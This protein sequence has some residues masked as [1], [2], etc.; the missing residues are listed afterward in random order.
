MALELTF[1]QDKHMAGDGS[2]LSKICLKEIIVSIKD[3]RKQIHI[4]HW[5]VLLALVMTH[6]GAYPWGGICSS[7]ALVKDV[8]VQMLVHVEFCVLQSL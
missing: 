8:H 5:M 6:R 3:V 1:Y 2:K 4:P 7:Q